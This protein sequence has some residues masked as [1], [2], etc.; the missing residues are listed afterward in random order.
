[1]IDSRSILIAM[2]PIALTL[3]NYA[4]VRDMLWGILL[5]SKSKKSANKI[6]AEQ[7]PWAKFTQ[8]YIQQ[9]L[10]KY[11]KEYQTWKTVKLV[12]CSLTIAQLIG[13]TAMIALGVKFWVIGV[14]CAAISV[15]NVVIFGIMMNKTESSDHKH[16]RKGSPWKFEQ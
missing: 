15:F 14:I 3:V 4:I 8:N 7:K 1:M 9:Y 16:D 6:K 2:L 13:F 10:T 12:L 11:Q 5:G